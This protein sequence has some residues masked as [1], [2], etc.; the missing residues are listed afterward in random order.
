[1]YGVG[2]LPSVNHG[3]V[4]SISL[5]EGGQW[6]IKSLDPEMRLQIKSSVIAGTTK[7]EGTLFIDTKEKNLVNF[8]IDMTTT[9]NEKVLPSFL[10]TKD[11]QI[12]F[13]ISEQKDVIPTDLW[14]LYARFFPLDQVRV[15]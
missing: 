14:S 11:K 10:R 4:T 15:L 3:E 8:D 9:G 2:S 12:F 13:D 7:G 5:A 1:M 6:I